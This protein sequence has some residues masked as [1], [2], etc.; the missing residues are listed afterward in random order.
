MIDGKGAN[1]SPNAAS[2]IQNGNQAYELGQEKRL[3]ANAGRGDLSA[4]L[5]NVLSLASVVTQLGKGSVVQFPQFVSKTL[6]GALHGLSEG[7]KQSLLKG[8]TSALK[9]STL[10]LQNGA[11]TGFANILGDTMKL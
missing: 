10:G 2:I 11:L 9:D 8:I 1:A 5:H 7:S 6:A 4:A 3:K